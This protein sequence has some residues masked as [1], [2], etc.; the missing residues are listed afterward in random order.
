MKRCLVLFNRRES[1]AVSFGGME[2]AYMGEPRFMK[3]KNFVPSALILS[4]SQPA[5][6]NNN[7]LRYILTPV[8]PADKIFLETC[9]GLM[10]L[11]LFSAFLITVSGKN[12]ELSP[13]YRLMGVKKGTEQLLRALSAEDSSIAP[14]Q[15]KR[16]VSAA[17][18]KLYECRADGDFMPMM[19]LMTPDYFAASGGNPDTPFKGLKIGR[20]DLLR[21]SV[22]LLHVN[23]TQEQEQRSFAA[24]IA[25]SDPKPF[26]E[27][28]TFRYRNGAW[29]LSLIEQPS[30]SEAPA[31][32]NFNW[33]AEE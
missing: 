25:A 3:L 2:Q 29:L 7:F 27:V 5:F 28:W 13:V 23:Y 22:D 12:G 14:E 9:C 24:L 30:E 33:R 6:A 18:L 15:L 26:Q 20:E 17:F 1:P 32:D 31:N 4:Y 21:V 16:L 10:V 8:T 19:P 11:M